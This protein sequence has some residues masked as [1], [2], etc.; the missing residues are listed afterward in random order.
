VVASLEICQEANLA[1]QFFEVVYEGPES[2]QDFPLW[3]D[4]ID[5]VCLEH[6]YVLVELKLIVFQILVQEKVSFKVFGSLDQP[7]LSLFGFLLS[8]F[9][10]IFFEVPRGEFC[11]AQLQDFVQYGLI[12]F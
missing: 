7:A 9:N 6:I 10:P 11:L 4:K 3:D 2:L 5:M 1:L 12:C 8:L